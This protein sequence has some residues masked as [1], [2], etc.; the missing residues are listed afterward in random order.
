MGQH[1]P[2]FLRDVQK[3]AMALLALLVFERGTG[4]LTIVLMVVCVLREMN[5]NV[6]HAMPGLGVEEVDGIV[7]GRQVAV[8]AV[9]HKALGI[10]HMG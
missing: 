10:V 9:G 2:P 8:H 6:L 3:I 1:G 4:L 5:G 7:R